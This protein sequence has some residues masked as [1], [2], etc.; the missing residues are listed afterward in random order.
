MRKSILLILACALALA[1]AAAF[2]AVAAEE[3][4]TYTLYLKNREV[5]TE[6]VEIRVLV[7]GHASAY[8]RLRPGDVEAERTIELTLEPGKHRLLVEATKAGAVIER[9]LV[10]DGAGSAEVE[11]WFFP[12]TEGWPH[13]EE[14][15]PPG[16]EGF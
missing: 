9:E 8:D 3:G 5:T 14:T 7:D 10:V 6:N 2:A 11:L 4:Y 1:T 12:E 13:L 15:V 16:E